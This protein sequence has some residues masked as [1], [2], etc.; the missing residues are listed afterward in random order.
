MGN[1]STKSVGIKKVEN[2]TNVPTTTP[3]SFSVDDVSNLHNRFK[4]LA[5]SSPNPNEITREQMNDAM[6]CSYVHWG[7]ESF[8]AS[9]FSAMDVSES[10]GLDFREF[11]MGLGVLSHGTPREKLNLSFNVYDSLNTGTISKF[12]LVGI[13]KAANKYTSEENLTDEVYI[14]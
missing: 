4:K 11:V 14:R 12:E 10:G 6:S 7:D 13:L 2:E 9:L 5:E 3:A 8:V 1:K